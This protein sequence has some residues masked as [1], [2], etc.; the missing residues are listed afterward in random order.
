MQ[1]NENGPRTILVVD[2]EETIR[3]LA[4]IHLEREGYRVLT[5]EN[6]MEAID[7]LQNQDVSLIITD[8]KM[9]KLN[10][11]G[12]L[13]YTKEHYSFIPVIMLTG[14]I[15]VDLAVDSMKKGTFHYLTKPFK[16]QELLAVVAD[17]LRDAEHTK[18]M[19][20]FTVSRVYLLSD[21]GT[22]ICHKDLS[23]AS[24]F[25]SDIFGSML[26]AVR[27]FIDDSFDRTGEEAKGFE[28][29]DSRILIEEGNGFFLVV[30]G[31]GE[32]SSVV[33]EKM[34]RTVKG[35]E[36]KYGSLIS[37]WKGDIDALV[38]IEAQLTELLEE[39]SSRSS[40]R[41]GQSQG[42]SR[43]PRTAEISQ[44]GNRED[45]KQRG[46]DRSDEDDAAF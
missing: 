41:G 15:D 42:T 25:D 21:G 4:R 8:I 26:T 34:R 20:F 9:P 35:I 31:V 39:G 10:G 44:G 12:L 11:F 24:K 2:D 43:E 45:E 33:R 32:K 18:K 38:G 29:G 28:Y 23:T 14:Y 5:A 17:A 46:K 36:E 30:V 27:M 1:V 16:K 6:G 7:V 37:S 22:L 40:L 19:S 3:D 13:D